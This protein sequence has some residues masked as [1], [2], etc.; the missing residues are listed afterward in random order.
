M[1]RRG[2]APVAAV[3]A[4]LLLAAPGLA[5]NAQG[6]DVSHY[7]G[8]IDWA[9]VSGTST[10]FAFAK[11][12]EGKT[13]VDVTYPLNRTGGVGVGI[14]MGAYHFARPGGSGD[15]AIV[16]DAISQADF[17][18]GVS[19]PAPGDLP[20]VLDLETTG[21]LKAPDLLTWTQGWLTEVLARTGVH[22]LVYTSPNFW[23]TAL[24]N[25]TAVASAGFPLWIAHW[26]TAASPLL[27]AS[28]WG[29]HSWTFWQWSSHSR[30][31]GIS[32]QV[33]ADRFHGASVAGATIPAY[34]SGAPASSA[35]PTVVGAAQSGKR[36][37][38]V[39]GSWSGGKPV[40]FSY[41]WLRCDAAGANCAPIPGALQET[42]LPSVLDV[43]HALAVSVTAQAQAGAATA[44]SPAT[45]AVTTTSSAAVR[46][47]ATTP[48][49]I[50]GTPQAGQI[51][52]ST[53]GA[54]SG[55]PSTFAYQWQRCS[56]TGA[57]CT[58][59]LGATAAAYTVTPGDIGFVIT[60][61]VTATGK[62]GSTSA[63]APPP[64]VVVAA[65][66]PT[67]VVGTAVAAAGSAG[68][69]SAADA[70]ATV[71]WQPGAVP[72]GSTVSLTR[73]GAALVFAVTPAP[74][75]LPWP[76]DLG[77]AAPVA[78][79]ILGYSTDG[80][81]WHA[82]PALA[83]ATLMPDEVAGSY[84]DASALTHVLLRV[85]ARVQLFQPN[86]WGNPRRVAAGPPKP[87]LVGRLT[88]TR[89]GNGAVL[90][91]GRVA[92]P[93]QAFLTLNVVGKT[94]AHRSRRL[95]P[96]SAIMR[97]AVSGRH[98]TRGAHAT[99]RVAARDPYGR[100]AALLV[101]FTAP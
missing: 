54:W 96:S 49:A 22:A 43:G 74:R 101:R 17:F 99:F 18:L 91:S 16:A 81:V 1:G 90:V 77:L 27:P 55:A 42:Y 61:V 93:S 82:I 48:P 2:V 51:L 4:A 25:S 50:A 28:G 38:A 80:R 21:G 72:D 40:S 39:P 63:V 11:A 58:A 75:I 67:A 7:Q 31:S 9:R 44:T 30:V 32:P 45:L 24:A 98:L 84:A 78:G 65:P 60:L 15:A 88:V 14:T 66:V 41:Q 97:V 13:L 59:I 83:A 86:Q 8:A 3:A 6:I 37:S 69:V 10:T 56:A 36:L 46:P 53:V 52:T 19:Q 5:A 34:P 70:S 20:P 92:V 95:R 87:R 23:K 29:G 12:T 71:T 79:Q 33:D 100:T 35:P 47:A 64:A 57:G 68:A 62:G 26:T 89:A 73:V 85:P 76:V 94:S